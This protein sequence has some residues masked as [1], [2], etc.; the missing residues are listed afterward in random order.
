MAREEDR[1][2]PRESGD[3]M[4][5]LAITFLASALGVG[6]TATSEEAKVPC[7]EIARLLGSSSSEKLEKYEIVRTVPLGGNESDEL[8]FNVDLDGDDISDELGA[9]CSRSNAPA[10]PCRLWAKLSSGKAIDFDF[11]FDD[12]FFLFRLHARIYVLTNKG[13]VHASK[14]K[15]NVYLLDGAGM[16]QVCSKI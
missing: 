3:D 12:Y 13:A 1:L 2:F 4:R 6:A 8:Y 9:G 16:N 10:D 15:R 11:E 7:D 14:G 5:K